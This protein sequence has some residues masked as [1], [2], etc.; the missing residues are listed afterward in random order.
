MNRKP[1]WVSVS[2]CCQS[3]ISGVPSCGFLLSSPNKPHYRASVEVSAAGILQS[4]INQMTLLCWRKSKRYREL[5]LH[6]EQDQFNI[7]GLRFSLVHEE[8]FTACS[9]AAVQTKAG[10]LV[11]NWKLLSLCTVL[12]TG[13]MLYWHLG[14]YKQQTPQRV[15][16]SFRCLCHNNPASVRSWTLRYK[17]PRGTLE[18]C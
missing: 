13:N 7:S 5:S 9:I 18:R 17:W 16:P 15:W 2:N 3:T 6:N 10:G 8:N 4:L 1:W 12:K 14:A 11:K